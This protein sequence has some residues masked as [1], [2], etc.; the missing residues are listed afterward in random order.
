MGHVNLK[1]KSLIGL[2]LLMICGACADRAQDPFSD[3]TAQ[4]RRD[5]VLQE[6]NLTED[7]QEQIKRLW[8]IQKPILEKK[9]TALLEARYQL[10]LAMKQEAANEELKSLFKELEKT[11]GELFFF[12][13]DTVI[14]IREMLTSEQKQ[15][16]FGFGRWP[17][18]NNKEPI[19]NEP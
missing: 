6:L 10:D 12:R 3:K 9:Q 14:A 17:R 7:Q 13:F 4:K 5:E 18:A 19:H 1:I 15:K 2:G 16:F 8:Q 11:R